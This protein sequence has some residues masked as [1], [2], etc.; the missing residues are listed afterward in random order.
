VGVGVGMDWEWQVFALS[1]VDKR[2]SRDE[3]RR[4]GKVSFI[5]HW[6]LLRVR[7]IIALSL[8]FSSYDF[9]LSRLI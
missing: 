9:K 3:V 2:R 6:V 4:K 7:F 5:A 1:V 8:V